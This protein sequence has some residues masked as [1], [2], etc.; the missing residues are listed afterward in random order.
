MLFRSQPP[1]PPPPVP[2][3]VAR[4]DPD[5]I[6]ELMTEPTWEEIMQFMQEEPLMSYRVDI[7][8]DSTIKIDQQAE[9]A[10]RVQFLT[11]AGG[12]IKEAMQ[13]QDPAMAPLLAKM[14]EFGLSSFKIGRDLEGEFEMTIKKLEKEAQNPQ[15]K[16]NPEQMKVQGQIQIQQAQF[17]ADKDRKSVV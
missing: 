1:L 17:E 13:V 15:P 12:F 16:P 11:T 9:Q 2:P 14:M 4:L 5:D 10:A 3:E 6:A 8:T 7:E